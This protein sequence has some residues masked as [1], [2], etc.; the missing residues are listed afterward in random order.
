MIYLRQANSMIVLQKAYRARTRT[1][2]LTRLTIAVAIFS[3]SPTA[4]IAQDYSNIQQVLQQH[5]VECHGPQQRE[6]GLRLDRAPWILRGGDSGPIIAREHAAESE[7]YKRITSTGDDR[8]PPEGP[9][10]SL[11]DIARLEHWINSN[12]PGLPTDEPM[13]ND[14]IRLQHWA[15]GKQALQQVRECGCSQNK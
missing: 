1:K 9:A 10:L 5:C 15:W 13:V 11:E 3:A 12:L 6:G 14:D 4:I 7:L 8:M 2:W